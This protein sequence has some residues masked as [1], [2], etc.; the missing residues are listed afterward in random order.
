MSRR[1]LWQAAL[2]LAVGIFFI[3]GSAQ[4]MGKKAPVEKEKELGQAGTMTKSY[5]PET[6]VKK[7][8]KTI[9]H[10]EKEMVLEKE[11][12][13]G[14][15]VERSWTTGSEAGKSSGAGAPSSHPGGGKGKGKW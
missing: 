4:A 12:H 14:A 3:A 2:V 13:S 11:P 5:D 15:T 7:M 8:E 6:G 9:G 10:G 1:N